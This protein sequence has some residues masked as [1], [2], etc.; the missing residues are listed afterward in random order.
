MLGATAS[1]AANNSRM[2]IARFDNRQ[3]TATTLPY[4][5]PPTP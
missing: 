1:A 4:T 2:V 5:A 3:R